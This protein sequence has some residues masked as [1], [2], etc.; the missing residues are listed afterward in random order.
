MDEKS[1]APRACYVLYRVHPD[2]TEELVSE[3]PDFVSGWQAGTRAVTVEDEE[4]A[5]SLYEGF[6][7]RRVAKF[8]H[9]RLMLQVDAERMSSMVGSL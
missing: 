4:N 5:Y 2:G 9:S 1:L 7:R 3:H 6:P 8:G